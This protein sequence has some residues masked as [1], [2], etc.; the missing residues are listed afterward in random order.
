MGVMSRKD[1]G[2]D[3]FIAAMRLLLAPIASF[4]IRKGIKIQDII[5]ELKRALIDAARKDLMLRHEVESVSRLSVMTGLQRKDLSILE[6]LPREK[7]ESADILSRIISVWMTDRKFIHSKTKSP[8]PLSYEGHRSEFA[9]LVR[10]VSAD[11]N[12]HTVLFE[13][14]R[15]L[16]ARKNTEART[17]L[18][19]KEEFITYDDPVESYGLLA[20]DVG[21]LIETVDAN[22]ITAPEQRLLHM[23]TQFDNVYEA[24]I[25]ELKAWMKHA[26][27]ALHSEART[28][29]S[30]YDADTASPQQRKQLQGHAGVKIGLGSFG[31]IQHETT[32]LTTKNSKKRRTT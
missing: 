1:L 12:H 26:G 31:F 4:C 30:K 16:V 28:I 20:R 13:L 15:A 8:R 11:L 7:T 2:R 24:A 3:I 6:D 17:V 27:K 25:P 5:P 29:L 21:A 32:T 14:E 10:L 18:L 22:I 9:E 19:L 23:T